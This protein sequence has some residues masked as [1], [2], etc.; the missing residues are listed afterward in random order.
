MLAPVFASM[1]EPSICVARRTAFPSG[2]WDGLRQVLPDA[3]GEAAFLRSPSQCALQDG[4]IGAA[5]A[6]LAYL[7]YHVE[8]GLPRGQRGFAFHGDGGLYRLAGLGPAWAC[9]R[10]GRSLFPRTAQTS[11]VGGA[12]VRP[13]NAGRKG[14]ATVPSFKPL[15]AAKTPT[16]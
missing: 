3:R 13:V 4:G 14:R 15:R 12:G 16:G 5:F 6:A 9:S 8:I 7:R 10:P 1:I 2:R 11:D